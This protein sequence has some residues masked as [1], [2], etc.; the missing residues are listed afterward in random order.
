M[1]S[2][3]L[4]GRASA[5]AAHAASPRPRQ[6][7]S[8]TPPPG[9]GRPLPATTHPLVAHARRKGGS[10]GDSGAAE[11]PPAPPPRDAPPPADLVLIGTIGAPH[12]LGGEFRVFPVTDEPEDRLKGGRRLAAWAAPR[13][14][15]R[16]LGGRAGGGGHSHTALLLTAGRPVLLKGKEVWLVRA[17]GVD[18]PEAAACLANQEL[19][20]SAADR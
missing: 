12:G 20:M 1:P 15:G 4:A 6:P 5:A 3:A 19:W 2:A 10:A 14:G 18:S 11:S 16:A 9:H 8:P 13:R 7:A 17:A